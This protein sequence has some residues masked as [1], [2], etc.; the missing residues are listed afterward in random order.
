MSKLGAAFYLQ[1]VASAKQDVH[2]KIDIML[3]P[4][5]PEL[6][7]VSKYFSAAGVKISPLN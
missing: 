4:R 3:L 5:R 2:C 1:F 6:C 7:Y